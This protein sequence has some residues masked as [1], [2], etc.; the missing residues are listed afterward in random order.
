MSDRLNFGFLS[1]GLKN[2]IDLLAY[3]LGVTCKE[4]I[5]YNIPSFSSMRN[6]LSGKPNLRVGQVWIAQDGY[7]VSDVRRLDYDF[8]SIMDYMEHEEIPLVH[9]ECPDFVTDY[10]ESFGAAVVSVARHYYSSLFD[11]VSYWKGKLE[12]LIDEYRP[13]AVLFSVGAN[14]LNENLIAYVATKKGIP[15]LFFEHCPFMWNVFT[16]YVYGSKR[17]KV[18]IDKCIQRDSDIIV[19]GKNFYKKSNSIL[20]LCATPNYHVYKDMLYHY[21]DYQNFLRHKAMINVCS[22]LSKDIHIKLHP[23][24][25]ET[26]QIYWQSL[27]KLCNYSRLEILKGHAEDIL[28]KYKIIIIDYLTTGVALPVICQNAVLIYYAPDERFL[29]DNLPVTAFYE[30]FYTARDANELRLLLSDDSITPRNYD[31]AI[32]NWTSINADESFLRE[33][34]RNIDGGKS[35]IYSS[36]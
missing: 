25:W 9:T 34:R 8:F 20:Y 13:K 21:S 10:F 29:P 18:T 17:H 6:F 7:S 28:H 16:K 11:S 15:V 19:K 27:R 22:E 5:S 3:L 35:S 31:F 30:V 4:D 2:K 26:E 32:G 23:T 36:C 14:R 1:F 24:E 12:T 33:V